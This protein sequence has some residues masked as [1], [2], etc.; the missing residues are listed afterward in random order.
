MINKSKKHDAKFVKILAVLVIKK[1]LDQIK[2]ESMEVDV[3]EGEDEALKLSN[4]QDSK[5][6]EKEKKRENEEIKYEQ[7]NKESL[8]HVCRL[9]V[10]CGLMT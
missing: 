4:L 7:Q 2:H 8:D 5:V 9:H 3:G 6:L 10:L 1:L